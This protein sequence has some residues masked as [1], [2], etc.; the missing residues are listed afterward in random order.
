LARAERSQDRNSIPSAGDA[1]AGSLGVIKGHEGQFRD[2][3]DLLALNAAA[4]LLNI[5][6]KVLRER[7]AQ[8]ESVI[9]ILRRH[10]AVREVALGGKDQD[11]PTAR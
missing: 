1:N 5:T 9:E 3:A 6:V 10:S 2:L 4:Q 8:K 7:M 11:P